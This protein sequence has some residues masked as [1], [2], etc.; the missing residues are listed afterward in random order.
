MKSYKECC[1]IV[2]NTHWG[3]KNLVI[4][5]APKYYEEAA[6][7]YASQFKKDNCKLDLDKISTQ[8]DEIINHPDFLE[9]FKKFC[10]RDKQK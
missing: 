2:A 3:G 5:H 6:E 10:E 9:D 1:S 8:V 4:G 7:M